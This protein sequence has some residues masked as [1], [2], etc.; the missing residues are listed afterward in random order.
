MK[1][2]FAA[3]LFTALIFSSASQSQ[4]VSG[5]QLSLN[6]RVVPFTSI[7]V[8]NWPVPPGVYVIYPYGCGAGGAGAGGY[9][10]GS[11]GG[12]GGGGAGQCL[13]S[14]AYALPVT[15]GE[16]LSISIGQGGAAGSIG[17]QGT[18]GASVSISGAHVYP[19]GF[20]SNFPTL[21]GGKSGFPGLSNSGG[22]GGDGGGLIYP[23]YGSNAGFVGGASGNSLSG[24]IP[25]GGGGG[26]GNPGAPAGINGGATYLQQSI[27]NSNGGNAGGGPGGNSMLGIGGLGPNG[28]VAGNAPLPGS[29]GAAGSGGGVTAAGGAGG[30]GCLFIAY[31]GQ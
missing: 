13:Q 21:P 2:I 23:G 3:V 15:P 29:C 28:S 25:G 1:K 20:V 18:A 26:G 5:G 12:G 11:G 17:F 10:L 4:T 16:T 31:W 7:G 9:S 14:N 24:I 30:N 19:S 8:Y 27:T 6:L 22:T